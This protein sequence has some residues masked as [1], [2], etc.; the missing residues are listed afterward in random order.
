V[1]SGCKHSNFRLS[2]LKVRELRLERPLFVIPAKAGIHNDLKILD[3]R[4]HGND[5]LDYF[6]QNSKVSLSGL[7][8]GRKCLRKKCYGAHL[9]IV[10]GKG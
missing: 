8:K 2:P 6:W 9:V 1:N 4:F 10:G 7:G 3:S 5:N